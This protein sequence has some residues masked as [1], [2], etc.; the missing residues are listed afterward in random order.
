LMSAGSLRRIYGHG[1]PP[2]R[3]CGSS[4]TSEPGP[5]PQRGREPG[6]DHH[7]HQLHHLHGGTVHRHVVADHHVRDPGGDLRPV[8]GRG[9]HPGGEV[10]HG[11]LPAAGAGLQFGRVL[12]HHRGRQRCQV[13]DLTATYPIAGPPPV[14]S[15]SHTP[16]EPRSG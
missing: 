13:M 11:G 1:T 2:R 12:G 5:A 9:A 6:R 10:T 14:V 7:P 8:P 16:P 4:A 3:C 15:R